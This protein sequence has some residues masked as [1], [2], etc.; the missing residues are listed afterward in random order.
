MEESKH[1]KFKRISE[2]R[3]KKIENDLRILS[4]CAGGNYDFTNEEVKAIF[5]T[6]ER[7]IHTIKELFQKRLDKKA[8]SDA[9]QANQ[10]TEPISVLGSGQ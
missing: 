7:D 1:E 2:K 10:T 3:I 4:N 5:E 6:L 9:S 8:A